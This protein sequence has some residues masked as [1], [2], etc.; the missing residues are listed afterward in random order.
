MPVGGHHSRADDIEFLHMSRSL[1]FANPDRVQFG[2]EQVLEA[3]ALAGYQVNDLVE[4]QAGHAQLFQPL[5]LYGGEVGAARPE[6]ELRHGNVLA[7]DLYQTF[8]QQPF[9]RVDHDHL[10]EIFLQ[11]LQPFVTVIL[12]A[13]EIVI[14]QGFHGGLAMARMQPVDGLGNPE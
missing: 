4:A 9:H 8:R 5:A 10:M 11:L 6:Q 2:K 14:L 7:A 1:F 13:A 12:Q 3:E